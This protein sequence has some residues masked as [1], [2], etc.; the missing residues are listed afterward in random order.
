M[1]RLRILQLA[2]LDN[3]SSGHEC[4]IGVDHAHFGIHYFP[5]VRGECA[6]LGHLNFVGLGPGS[7]VRIGQH[8]IVGED[9]PDRCRVFGL[10]RVGPIGFRFFQGRFDRGG[11]DGFWS[12]IS[13]GCQR[14]IAV[15]VTV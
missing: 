1:S 13:V 10:V 6:G 9:A 15:R 2:I 14:R 8:D 3:S 7:S 11:V 5:G 4:R 12:R